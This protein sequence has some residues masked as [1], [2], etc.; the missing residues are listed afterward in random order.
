M[1]RLIHNFFGFISTYEIAGVIPLDLL[2]HLLVGMIITLV[3]VYKNLSLKV[4]FFFLLLVALGKE[5]NDYIF[6]LPRDPWEYISDFLI[7]FTYIA[8]LFGTRKLKQK[9]EIRHKKSL[10]K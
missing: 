2:L 6:H 7:T 1:S 10:N 9:L 5:L 4:I 3:G 8:L